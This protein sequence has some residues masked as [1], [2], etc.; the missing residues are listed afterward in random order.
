MRLNQFIAKSGFSSR[1][2]A[3]LFI[4]AGKV[5][6]NKRVIFEPYFEVKEKDKVTIDSRVLRLEKYVYLIFNKP[7]GVTTTL[8]DRFAHKKVSDFIPKNL[9][10]LYP[11]GRLDK[12]S[13]GLLIL[14]NDGSLCYELTHPKFEVEKEYIAWVKGDFNKSLLIKLKKGVNSGGEILK[15]KSISIETKGDD[16]TSLKVVIREGKKRHLRRLFTSLGFSVLDLKRIRIGDLRLGNL[17][18]G[19]FKIVSKES[20]YRLTRHFRAA[21]ANSCV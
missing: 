8:K 12:N 16:R 21:D 11:V 17:E 20:I 6:V 18:E 14:T 19:S 5:R 3:D 1:R 2:K 9:G 7:E 4:K 15:V 10:R 13:K